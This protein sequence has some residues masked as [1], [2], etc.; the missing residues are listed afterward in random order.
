MAW[1]DSFEKNFDS[2][3]KALNKFKDDLKTQPELPE[4]TRK[5]C[6]LY[7]ELLQAELEEITLNFKLLSR[8]DSN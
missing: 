1:C 5:R 7:L 2:S 4:I 3:L 6:T 8:E